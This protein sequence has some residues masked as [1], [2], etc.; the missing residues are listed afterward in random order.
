MGRKQRIL[1]DAHVLDGKPQG[2][3]AYISGLYSALAK[4]GD[5]E[6]LLAS[7]RSESLE[8]WFDDH[9]NLE[10]VP[11]GTGNKY[12]RLALDFDRLARRHAPDFMH[13]QYIT[14]L[15]KRCRWINTIHDI[16]FLD[17][18]EMFPARYRQ[19]NGTLF[20][21]SARRSD[22]V[23]T[24][25]DYSRDA[26]ARHFAIPQGRIHVTPN[27]VDDWG[28]SGQTAIP[29]LAGTAF[30]VY[31]SRFEPRKNQDGLVRAF[32][33]VRDTLPS[34]TRLV[35]VG[36][37]AMPY[38]A[39]EREL[40]AA[41]ASVDVLSNLTREELAW[42]YRNAIAAIYPSR[43][44]GFGIPPLEAVAAG[45]RSICSD[46]TAMTELAPFVHRTFDSNDPTALTTVLLDAAQTPWQPRPD[47]QDLV[48]R[49][50]SWDRAA[51]AFVHAIGRDA[52]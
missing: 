48:A 30:F 50:Y 52:T 51:D 44:E 40:S 9:E 45:G 7:E 41:G 18:P 36:S 46:N 3:C 21:L 28:H 4:R 37:M 32:R 42:L 23:L 5:L 29:H 47:L 17:H 33:Q 19:V 1:V 43:A 2:T 24:V 38:P 26:I 6:I 27:G 25:S 12:K 39:L 22:V 11:L 34:E 31:V 15:R 10:W 20:R 8:R 13:F 16:L 14:P 49:H 35:L